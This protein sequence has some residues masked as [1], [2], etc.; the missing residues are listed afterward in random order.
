MHRKKINFGLIAIAAAVVCAVVF[1]IAASGINNSDKRSIEA[2]LN[3]FSK[4]IQSFEQADPF[5]PEKAN[6]ESYKT[7]RANSADRLLGKYYTENACSDVL[8]K[9]FLSKE[10]WNNVVFD[11]SEAEVSFSGFDKADVTFI[12]YYEDTEGTAYEFGGSKSISLEMVKKDGQW[13]IDYWNNGNSGFDFLDVL[14]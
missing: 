13:L 12:L 10:Q 1:V 2:V 11:A 6:D 3:D 9:E 7:A 14:F 5:D 8:K 4:G